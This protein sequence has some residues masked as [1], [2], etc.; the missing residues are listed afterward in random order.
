MQ[1]ES[2]VS[3][4]LKKGSSSSY[5]AVFTS[6]FTVHIHP[7]Q[8]MRN[9]KWAMCFFFKQ[10]A[11]ALAR[12]FIVLCCLLLLAVEQKKKKITNPALIDD[13][14]VSK[15]KR[16]AYFSFGII[17]KN[18]HFTTCHR[19]LYCCFRLVLS[20]RFCYCWMV[21]TLAIVSKHTYTRV[22]SRWQKNK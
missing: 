10:C 18:V 4:T 7:S 15:D 6:L 2:V 17:F 22:Q 5:I 9:T 11:N 21:C 12:I 3:T 20:S 1:Y 16:H 8:Q 13:S 14:A 19:L